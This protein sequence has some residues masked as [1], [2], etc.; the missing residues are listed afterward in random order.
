M[1]GTDEGPV[2]VTSST[3]ITPEELAARD[4]SLAAQAGTA[5]TASAAASAPPMAQDAS[6]APAAASPFT[7]A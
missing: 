6:A 1:S 7:G 2:P 4:A 3:S 5:P